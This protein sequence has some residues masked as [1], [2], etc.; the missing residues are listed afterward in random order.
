MSGNLSVLIHH[1]E[2]NSRE[3]L[4]IIA[5]IF[6][7]AVKVFFTRHYLESVKFKR[8]TAKI[9][10]LLKSLESPAIGVHLKLHQ[11]Q[12]LELRNFEL[13]TGIALND[14]RMLEPAL[15]K[16]KECDV[17]DLSAKKCLFPELTIQSGKL[18]LQKSKV[19]GIIGL[20]FLAVIMFI[21][22]CGMF[23]DGYLKLLALDLI[24][25]AFVFLLLAGLLVSW[26]IG[27]LIMAG[28]IGRAFHY[29]ALLNK[30][31][32]N[33]LPGDKKQKLKI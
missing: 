22:G 6:I 12:Q 1:Y 18:H 17:D 13:T 3:I 14:Y 32:P 11:K 19:L 31:H 7:F 20:V 24:K 8:L 21:L 26:G 33:A 4:P 5:V 28:N 2:S 27:Y 16:I 25:E 15:H 10:I 29:F 23:V 9:N 30:L